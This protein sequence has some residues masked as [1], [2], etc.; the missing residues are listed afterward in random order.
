MGK[1]LPEQ[2]MQVLMIRD[3]QGYIARVQFWLE[4]QRFDFQGSFLSEKIEGISEL[5]LILA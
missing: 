2:K 3:A 5:F 1:L 4:T